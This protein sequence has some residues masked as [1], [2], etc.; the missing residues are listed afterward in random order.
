MSDLEFKL[1]HNFFR[2]TI[3]SIKCM[4][5]SNSD[6]TS[7]HVYINSPYKITLSLRLLGYYETNA[8]T[9]RKRIQ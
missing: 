5:N 6:I 7:L 8:P 3:S 1:I 9:Y 4:K 2:V